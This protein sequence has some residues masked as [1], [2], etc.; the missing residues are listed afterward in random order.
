MNAPIL[1]N[2]RFLRFLRFLRS[3]FLRFPIPAIPAIPD[4]PTHQI[5]HVN[6]VSEFTSNIDLTELTDIINAP[7]YHPDTTRLSSDQSDALREIEGIVNSQMNELNPFINATG[8]TVGNV[9]I[10]L[11]S[12]PAPTPSTD[13]DDEEDED[14]DE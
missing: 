10:Q 13:E 3:A 6:R 11:R 4:C 7:G 8:A 9:S 2:A 12:M 1:L 14:E 5:V